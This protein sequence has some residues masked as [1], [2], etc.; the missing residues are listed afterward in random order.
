MKRSQLVVPHGTTTRPADVH[1][2]LGA[3]VSLGSLTGAPHHLAVR[4]AE[5]GVHFTMQAVNG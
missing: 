2:A 3:V 1:V 5:T 4:R